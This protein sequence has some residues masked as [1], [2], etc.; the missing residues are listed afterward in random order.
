MLP[1]MKIRRAALAAV[2]VLAAYAIE[3]IDLVAE[4]YITYF[5][6]YSVNLVCSKLG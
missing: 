3:F 5:V 1:E 4:P 2:A 6:A